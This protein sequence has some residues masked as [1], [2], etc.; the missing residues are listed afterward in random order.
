M[1][2][3][4]NYAKTARQLLILFLF[5][6][7]TACG[8]GGGSSASPPVGSSP[9]P[10]PAPSPQ[11]PGEEIIDVIPQEFI[12]DGEPGIKEP[13]G[14]LG[15]NLE[16]NFH[17]ITGQ[18]TAAKNIYKCVRKAGLEVVK[19]LVAAEESLKNKGAP[20]KLGS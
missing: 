8:G 9:P 16:A 14:M 19:V 5:A 17:I 2:F 15:N 20:V 10:P 7:I 4:G 18:T 6:G 1:N 3:V 13:I 12:I 11:D